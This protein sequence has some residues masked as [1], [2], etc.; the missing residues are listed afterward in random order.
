MISNDDELMGGGG[1]K[2]VI[3]LWVFLL[4]ARKSLWVVYTFDCKLNGTCTGG[5]LI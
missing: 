3:L 2:K 5:S 4:F 1:G